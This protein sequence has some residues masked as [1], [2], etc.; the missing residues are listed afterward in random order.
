MVNFANIL[1]MVTFSNRMSLFLV[2]AKQLTFCC[3]LLEQGSKIWPHWFHAK[4]RHNVSSQIGRLPT[5]PRTIKCRLSGGQMTLDART[6][7]RSVFFL[8]EN[9]T[10]MFFPG[11]LLQYQF[12]RDGSSSPGRRQNIVKPCLPETFA[13]LAD[14]FMSS[15]NASLLKPRLSS[16]MIWTITCSLSSSRLFCR[17]WHAPSPPPSHLWLFPALGFVHS[18]ST[19]AS[20]TLLPALIWKLA[21]T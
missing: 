3:F 7:R 5:P 1:K 17:W 20:S 2:T 13:K 4:R 11:F 21:L 15:S 10:S 8:Y 9:L 12:C 19:L 16:S 6:S 18:F 14:L